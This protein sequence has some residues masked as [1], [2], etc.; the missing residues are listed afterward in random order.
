MSTP[1]GAYC[2]TGNPSMT[3]VTTVLA[4]VRE[5]HDAYVSTRT[6]NDK[7]RSRRDQAVLRAHQTGASYQEIADVLGVKRSYIYQI[8]RREK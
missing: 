8:C 7:A 6:T 3:D 2:R 1:T 4:R 5:A